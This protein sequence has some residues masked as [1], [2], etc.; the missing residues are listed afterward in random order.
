MIRNFKTLDIW[1][2]SRELVKRIYLETEQ[3][4]LSEKFGLVSQMRRAAISIPSNIAEGCG[5]RSEKGLSNFL[6]IAIG[7][8]CELETQIYLSND[9]G[10]LQHQKTETVVKEI[11]QIRKMIIGFQKTLKRE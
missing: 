2:R 4:P 9:L 6:D 5:R 7:S 10:Y 1:V 8:N 3:F 11:T